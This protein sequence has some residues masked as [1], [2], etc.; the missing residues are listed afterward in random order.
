MQAKKRPRPAESL[1]L[2]L[3][4]VGT[5][6]CE[7]LPVALSLFLAILIHEC[8]HI[9]AYSL[10]GM[11]LPTLGVSGL[12]LRLYPSRPM[13]FGEQLF[14]ALAGPLANLLSAFLLYVC[15]GFGL[16]VWLHLLTAIANLLPVSTL[17]GGHILES[18]F[19]LCFPSRLTY[20]L[21]RCLSLLVILLGLVFALSALWTRGQGSYLFFLF[22]SLFLLHIFGSRQAEKEH[23]DLLSLPY[24]SI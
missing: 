15:F 18:L 7:E 5:L 23:T 16:P 22:F 14:V 2:A 19:A 11:S 3:W 6:C 13:S 9:L 17:D 12:G 21:T 1:A 4:C 10:V 24:R 8:G 20:L